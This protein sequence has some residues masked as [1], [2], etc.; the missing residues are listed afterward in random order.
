MAETKKSVNNF[1]TAFRYGMKFIERLF[2]NIGTQ[3]SWEFRQG[4]RIHASFTN[5]H[6]SRCATNPHP[7]LSIIVWLVL[8]FLGLYLFIFILFWWAAL[9]SI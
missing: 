5:W 2:H 9:K 3:V 6:R 1:L 7:A 8:I 4:K